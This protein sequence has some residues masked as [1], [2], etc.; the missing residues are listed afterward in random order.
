MSV[1][2]TKIV[3][4]IKAQLVLD[5][6]PEDKI[7]PFLD[8]AI[9]LGGSM[10]WRNNWQFAEKVKSFSTVANTVTYQVRQKLEAGVDSILGIRRLTTDDYG[11]DLVCEASHV[12]DRLYPYPD[13]R[14][15]DRPTSY[16][17]YINN[18][19]M[20]IDLF[21]EPDTAYTLEVTYR[22]AWNENRFADIP[23][24]LFDC[25]TAACM[26]YAAPPSTRSVHLGIYKAILGE[27]LRAANKINRK[28]MP[29][30]RNPGRVSAMSEADI[31][32]ERY[33]FYADDDVT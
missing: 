29:G 31:A 11:L 20:Y 27:A 10:F 22:L 5:G 30:V 26:V 24:S 18:G 23:D 12:F 21:P 33:N 28:R 6:L 17:V 3:D 32:L 14:D 9:D 25:I 8:T 16:K 4:Y 19:N 2:R 7:T 13:A 1:N 15:T